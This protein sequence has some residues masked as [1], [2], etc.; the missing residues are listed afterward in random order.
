MFVKLRHCNAEESYKVF[1]KLLLS[2]RLLYQIITL[3]FTPHCI[4]LKFI[5]LMLNLLCLFRVLNLA[6]SFSELEFSVAL[7]CDFFWIPPSSLTLRTPM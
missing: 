3:L 2:G 6:R 7:C 5:I 4:T 1:P